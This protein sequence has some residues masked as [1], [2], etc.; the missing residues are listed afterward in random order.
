MTDTDRLQRYADLIVR[1]GADLQQGQTL[2]VLALPEHTELVRA[3]ARSGYAAGA[4]YVDVLYA[5]P[6]VRKTMIEHADE[7]T[8]TYSPPWLVERY[9][10]AADGGALIMI[11]GEE[12]PELLADADQ[13]RVGKARLIDALAEIRRGQG[14][15]TM[16]WTIAAWPTAG[17]A[18]QIFGEPDLDRLWDAIASSVGLD[19]EDPVASWK[20]HVDKLRNRARQLNDLQLD[21]LHYEGP[22]TDLTVGLLESHK[23]IGGG[24]ETTYGAFHV[25]NMPTEEVFTTPD[26]NRADG[27]VR[28]TYP[29]QLGGTVVRDLE[30]RLEGG[31][32][33]DV[34][35]SSGEDAVRAQLDT[36]EGARHLGELALVDGESRVGKTGVTFFNTLFDENATCHIAF[37]NAIMFGT[38]GL[39]GL[40][41]DELVAKGFNMSNVHTDFMIGGPEVTVTGTT[42]D[43]REVTILKEDVW[44]LS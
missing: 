30:F 2:F 10:H 39:D 29:L 25:P 34:K 36:D 8:L 43:G 15:R 17:W 23:W 5:D 24:V 6:H 14:G 4:S 35:A 1:V 18:K 31:K 19:D 26:R 9:K 41:P 22:G 27:V 20:A 21:A 32:I 28:S 7:E 12:E 13:A 16:A 37:G 42:R 40:S 3:L 33:V 38:N 11:A 44:Q